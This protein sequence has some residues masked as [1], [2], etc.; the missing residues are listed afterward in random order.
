VEDDVNIADGAVKLQLP[1]FDDAFWLS[2]IVVYLFIYFTSVLASA[3]IGW[4]R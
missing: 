1:R 3:P 4:D 2:H